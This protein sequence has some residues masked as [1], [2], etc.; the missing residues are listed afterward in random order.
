MHQINPGIRER[1][2]RIGDNIMNNKFLKAFAKQNPTYNIECMNCHRKTKVKTIEFFSSNEYDF[3]CPKCEKTTRYN[4][5]LR[6]LKKLE[7][8]L[9]KLGIYAN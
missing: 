8:E 3:I 2:D 5:N 9:N 4:D 6:E 7:K 1:D